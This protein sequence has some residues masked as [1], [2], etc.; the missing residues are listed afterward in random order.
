MQAATCIED[1]LT[2][3]D[4]T[5]IQSIIQRLPSFLQNSK[6]TL[7]VLSYALQISREISFKRRI[8][9]TL[10]GTNRRGPAKV[11]IVTD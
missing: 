2:S 3:R 7:N 8:L 10:I 11:A 5:I 9:T 1:P 6:R 4:I